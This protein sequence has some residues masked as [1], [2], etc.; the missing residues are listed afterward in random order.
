MCC[1]SDLSSLNHN[2]SHHEVSKQEANLLSSSFDHNPTVVN[3]LNSTPGRTLVQEPWHLLLVTVIHASTTLAFSLD[4]H[5]HLQ[6][7]SPPSESLTIRADL[8]HHEPTVSI[9]TN[10]DRP[11]TRER[12]RRAVVKRDQPSSRKITPWN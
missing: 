10:L 5:H 1:C 7:H 6:P 12:S 11:S 8:N 2:Q 9:A 4:I 3:R